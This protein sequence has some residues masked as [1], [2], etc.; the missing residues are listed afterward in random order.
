M[1]EN[2]LIFYNIVKNMTPKKKSIIDVK[3]LTKLK[4]IKQ[5]A[6]S[7]GKKINKND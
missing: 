5:S 1:Y 2:R 4:N 7:D 6:V 3:K